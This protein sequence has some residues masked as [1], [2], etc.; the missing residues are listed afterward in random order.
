MR[1][2]PSNKRKKK[3]A[4]KDLIDSF[5]WVSANPPLKLSSMKVD[6]LHRPVSACNVDSGFQ[7][8]SPSFVL[9]GIGR[10]SVCSQQTFQETI[11]T[12]VRRSLCSL[13][14]PESA[15]QR[16]KQSNEDVV[17]TVP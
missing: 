13:Y 4:M 16:K 7:L 5:V 9:P 1:T 8:D 12:C 15:S 14:W 6:R 3:T 17:S 10:S 11:V 2:T